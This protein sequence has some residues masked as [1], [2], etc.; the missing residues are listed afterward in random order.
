[1]LLKIRKILWGLVAFAAAALATF[2]VVKGDISN[3]NNVPKLAV[4]TPMEVLEGT[5]QLT[6]NND[7]IFTDGDLLKKPSVVFFGFTNC[8]D[9]CPTGLIELSELLEKLGSAADQ[10]QVLFVA[11]DSKRDTLPVVRE[12]LTSFDPRII[13]LTGTKD[14]IDAAV[15]TFNA[16]YEIIP[17]TGPDDYSVNHT[18]GMFLIDRNKRFVGKLDK[19]ESL[20]VRLKKVKLLI[21]R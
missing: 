3:R 6:T 10:V 5:F 18:A 15:K 12:Y 21:E 7:A 11:V 1:M 17:G 13:G 8:P 20:E 19:D 2:Y 16:Y 14:E 9:I 4:A